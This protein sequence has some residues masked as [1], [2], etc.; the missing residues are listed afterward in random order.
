MSFSLLFQNTKYTNAVD[1]GNT[2]IKSKSELSQNASF[3]AQ[4]VVA[5]EYGDDDI[6]C[7]KQ[8]KRC[9]NNEDDA[10]IL[11]IMIITTLTKM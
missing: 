11:K 3:T 5:T 7:T 6:P 8:S 9:T 1:G 2:R 4:S 10:T